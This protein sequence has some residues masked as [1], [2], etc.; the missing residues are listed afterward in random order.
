[1]IFFVWFEMVTLK[2]WLELD[3]GSQPMARAGMILSLL[4]RFHLQTLE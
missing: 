4:N 1:M 3:T 2:T